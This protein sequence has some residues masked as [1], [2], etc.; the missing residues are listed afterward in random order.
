MKQSQRVGLIGAIVVI[1]A[2]AWLWYAAV[3]H[4]QNTGSE[5]AQQLLAEAMV[6]NS[7]PEMLAQHEFSV[8]SGPADALASWPLVRAIANQWRPTAA[9]YEIRQAALVFNDGSSSPPREGDVSVLGWMYVFSNS[10]DRE[11]LVV[12]V[13]GKGVSAVGRVPDG[14]DFPGRVP[15]E[16]IAVK[17]ESENAV[18]L[19]VDMGD[20]TLGIIADFREGLVSSYPTTELSRKRTYTYIDAVTGKSVEDELSE[21]AK[22]LII[23]SIHAPEIARGMPTSDS[24]KMYTLVEL[25]EVVRAFKADR[26]R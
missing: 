3:Q 8:E 18:I 1:G 6:H 22:S 10:A 26:L 25:G 17:P 14:F 5:Q 7:I 9:C 20:G 13:T 23:R 15:I 19:G 11:S 2:L 21:S 24:D 12:L 4:K 16:E